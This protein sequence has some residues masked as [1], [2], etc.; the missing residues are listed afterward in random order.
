MLL[1]KCMNQDCPNQHYVDTECD[2]ETHSW[3]YFTPDQLDPY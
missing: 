2:A 1:C 3:W